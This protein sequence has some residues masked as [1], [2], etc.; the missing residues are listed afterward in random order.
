M[1]LNFDPKHTYNPKGKVA[2]LAVGK[3]TSMRICTLQ[4]W[5]NPIASQMRKIPLEIIFFGLGKRSSRNAAEL[6]YYTTLPNIT[7]RWQKNAW[8]DEAV[9]VR[10]IASFREATLGD[11]EVLLIMDRHGP[12]RTLYCK[13]FMRAFHIFTMY[14]PSLC[15]DRIAPIDHHDRSANKD[16]QFWGKRTK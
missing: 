9:F 4:L 13:A 12:Q 15:T 1:E 10:S 6:D 5:I 16:V 2:E 11:G 7:V 8:C 14:T 3:E